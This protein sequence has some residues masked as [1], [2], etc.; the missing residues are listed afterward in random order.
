MTTTH[1]SV[2]HDLGALAHRLA[3]PVGPPCVCEPPRILADRPDGTV[4]R[5]GAVVAKAHAADT[6][7]E[8]LAARIALAA[9]PGLA[10]ILLPPLTAPEHVERA[11][12]DVRPATPHLGV[13]APYGS[14]TAPD[15][16]V[17]TSCESPAASDAGLVAPRVGV[18]APAGSPGAPGGRPVS[19]WPLGTPV[20][21]T[22][23]GAAPWAEAAELLARLH[24]TAPPFPLPPMRG[25]AKAARAVARM[26]A[27]RPGDPA[28]LPVLAG[29]RTLPAWARDEAAPPA[30][31]SGFLCHGD[32]HL[33]QLVRHPVPDGPWL[34]IDV[35]DA[36]VGDP[37]W[38]LARPA[39]WYAA[40]LLAPE[41]WS[42]FLHAYRSAG[43]PAVPAG[44]DPWPVLDVPARALTVQTAAVAL[45]KCAV[46]QRDPDAHEQL[47]I[48]SCARIATLPPELTP[49]PAS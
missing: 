48:E 13:A 4:V 49:G 46:E 1:T 34:L 44:G 14:I 32:L 23:P 10:G 43:G 5:S 18:A 19:L 47:M 27:V 22:D 37:A 36:G 21:P 16:G 3:H 15:G 38:D 8:A 9:A 6:D 35:D 7:R 11:E 30:L 29:W 25:P 12:Q 2:V 31:R 41:D 33:G 20:D 40:G 24:R 26:S 45:A 39:A 17:A 28:L 42:V